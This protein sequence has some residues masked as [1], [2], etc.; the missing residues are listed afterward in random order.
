MEPVRVLVADDHALVRAGIRAL[1]EQIE[2]VEVIAETGNGRDALKLI[3][4]HRPRLVLLDLTMP[5]LN[6]F[7]V[8]E[9]TCREFPEVSIIV[10]TVHEGEEY[11]LRALKLGAMGYLPKS[12]ASTELELAIMTVLANQ[13]YVSP[14]LSRR[15]FLEHAKDAAQHRSAGTELTPRQLEVLRM[16][17][18]G[19]TTKD[20]ARSLEISV[21]TV[22]SHR[23]QLMDRLNIHDVAG[24]VRHAIKMGLVTID[25]ISQVFP[26][27]I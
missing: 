18:D 7:D 19:K 8:L 14:E 17:A 27:D 20:I 21:K 16:I 11:A 4:E 23:A 25:G 5:E 1:A 12:A 26:H 15:T 22:E 6:G 10:L 2:G 24:L 13:K 3:A 9:R